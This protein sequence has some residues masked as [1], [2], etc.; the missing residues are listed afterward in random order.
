MFSK[1]DWMM[2]RNGSGGRKESY[3]DHLIILA[4]LG[5]SASDYGAWQFR[6][7]GFLRN[8]P[9]SGKCRWDDDGKAH[10]AQK[11]ALSEATACSGQLDGPFDSERGVCPRCDDAAIARQSFWSSLHWLSKLSEARHPP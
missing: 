3:Q 10:S 11:M 7:P 1:D 6:P 2:T 4:V 9:R 8:R 5:K